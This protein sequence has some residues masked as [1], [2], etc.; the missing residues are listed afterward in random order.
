MAHQTTRQ[1]ALMAVL[2]CCMMIVAIA[3][4][5]GLNVQIGTVLTQAL[6]LT[7]VCAAALAILFFEPAEPA[8]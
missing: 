4:A 1:I 6:P 5:S 3:V 7:L 8:N 2:T